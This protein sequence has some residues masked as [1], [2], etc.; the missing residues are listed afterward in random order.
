MKTILRTFVVALALC[1]LSV[2]A[3]CGDSD[4]LTG[5]DCVSAIANRVWAFG[6]SHPEGFTLD[7]GSMTQP[8][9]GI[10]VGFA[11]PRNCH[12]RAQLFRRKRLVFS[13][14]NFQ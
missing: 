3:A 2:L 9:D 7:I 1:G 4:S 14:N 8:M 6:Q 5:G 11:E 10:A 12:W 13:D